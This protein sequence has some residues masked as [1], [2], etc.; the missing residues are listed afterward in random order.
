MAQ[1]MRGSSVLPVP[2]A[3]RLLPFCKWALGDR[4]C[5]HSQ[6]PWCVAG[7]TIIPLPPVSPS[8]CGLPSSLPFPYLHLSSFSSFL[9]FSLPPPPWLLLAPPSPLCFPFPVSPHPRPLSR[10]D[11]VLQGQQ[12][13]TVYTSCSV[14]AASHLCLKQ[15]HILLIKQRRVQNPVS[16]VEQQK[17]RRRHSCVFDGSCF[18]GM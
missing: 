7:F 10:P 13:N 2:S 6:K 12:P 5:V 8:P 18:E 4:P 1:L 11:G 14:R 9:L 16:S 17:A 3:S 15:Q